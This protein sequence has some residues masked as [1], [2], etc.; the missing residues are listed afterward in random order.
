[1]VEL[2]PSPPMFVSIEEMSKAP[3]RGLQAG[4]RTTTKIFLVLFAILFESRKICSIGAKVD[5]PNRRPF[6]LMTTT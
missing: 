4:H 3:A 1:M 5:Q 6:F 2:A